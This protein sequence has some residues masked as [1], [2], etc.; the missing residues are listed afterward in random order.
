MVSVLSVGE[1]N[2]IK[3]FSEVLARMQNSKGFSVATAGVNSSGFSAIESLRMKAKGNYKHVTYDGGH[4]AVIAAVSGETDATTQLLS[5]QVEMIKAGRLRPLVALSD[6]PVKVGE[7]IIPAITDFI[8]DF[9]ASPIYFGIFVPKTVP[10]EVI[11]RLEK[12]WD[13]RIASAPSLRSYADQKGSVIAVHYG[14][15]AQRIVQPSIQKLAWL[16]YDS[17]RAKIRPDAVGIKR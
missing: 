4:P 10:K 6:K 15:K 7:K 12:V 13:S 17:G 1:H 5:E 3:D 14:E 8:P 11:R 9:K 2:S 16:L